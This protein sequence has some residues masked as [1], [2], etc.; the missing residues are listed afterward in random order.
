MIEMYK[1]MVT[2]RNFEYKVSELFLNGTIGGDLH[3]SVG[4]EACSVG[5]CSALRK[6]DTINVTHRG[7]GECLAKGADVRNMMAEFFGKKTGICKGKGGSMH[8]ADFKVGMLGASGIVGGGI[9]Q[10]VGA[11]LAMKLRGTDQVAVSF[12][13]DGASNQGTFHEALNLAAVWHLPVIFVCENNLY[14]ESTHVSKVMLVKNVADRAVAYGMPGVIVD[15]MDVLAAYDKMSDIVAE[16]RKGKGPTL[17]ECKTYRFEGH[18]VG[19]PQETYRSKEEVDEW[20]KKC[21]IKMM[22][23][24]LIDNKILKEAE[25]DKIDKECAELIEEAVKFAKESP[26]PEPKEAFEDVFVSP[27]Y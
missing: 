16:T 25:V 1:K 20:K 26:L 3:L 22:R 15:G 18:E 27:Y 19:D 17:L 5:V 4:E 11:A 10:S 13:G 6:D 2:I 14:A 21:P 23:K 9:P 7:H 24:Y 8:L 12:F